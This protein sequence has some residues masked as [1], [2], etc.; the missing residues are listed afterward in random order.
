[1]NK[2]KDVITIPKTPITKK[3]ENGLIENEE[4]IADTLISALKDIYNGAEITLS[5]RKGT[6]LVDVDVHYSNKKDKPNAANKKQE[7]K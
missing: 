3:V 6:D 1:M 7:N 4:S 2:K 5:K